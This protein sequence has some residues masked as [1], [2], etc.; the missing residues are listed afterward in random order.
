MPALLAMLAIMALA[1]L[2][3]MPSWRYLLA[4][5]KEQEL[6]FRGRQI[7]AAIARFQRRNGNAFPASIEQLVQGK[8]LR[9][10]YKDPLMPDGKWRIM[11]PGETGPQRPGVVPPGGFSG[12]TPTPSPT[13]GSTFGGNTGGAGGPVAGVAS[14]S[15]ESGFRTVNGSAN[16]SRW[17]FAPNIQLIIGG[18][19]AGGLGGPNQVPA[20][21][22]LRV[23]D[24]E[25]P[26]LSR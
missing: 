21:G 2:I 23:P 22:R 1:L 13:P 15:T 20:Q 8:Y 26:R 18:Q 9:Q 5:D 24:A 17:I 25:L 16:Y 11:R 3:A 10:A 12:P 4:E 19:Q 6:L 14:R 7:S